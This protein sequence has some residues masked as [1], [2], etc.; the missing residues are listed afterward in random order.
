MVHDGSVFAP[1][2]L[3]GQTAEALLK[4][5]AG[6]LLG[7]APDRGGGYPPEI[8]ALV[9]REYIFVVNLPLAQITD[10]QDDFSVSGIEQEDASATIQTTKHGPRFQ[11]SVTK[12]ATTGLQ[13]LPNSSSVPLFESP[14]KRSRHGVEGFVAPVLEDSTDFRAPRPQ[15]PMDMSAIDGPSATTAFNEM[16]LVAHVPKTPAKAIELPVPADLLAKLQSPIS[17]VLSSPMS[18]IDVATTPSSH[19]GKS[20]ASSSSNPAT[21]VQ[22]DKLLTSGSVDTCVVSAGKE[23]SGLTEKLPTS[24]GLPKTIPPSMLPTNPL[25]NPLAKVKVEKLEASMCQKNKKKGF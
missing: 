23:Q 7:A 24:S 25:S 14:Q 8:E 11:R 19:K 1:F 4:V 10:S 5:S 12:T 17:A 15:Q 13:T 2:V 20:S 6:T 22:P 16:L 21:I 3:L 18:G 9:G